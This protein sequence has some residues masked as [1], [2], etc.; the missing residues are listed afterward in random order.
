MDP[1][2]LAQKLIEVEASGP[3]HSVQAMVNTAF[4]SHWN[5]LVDRYVK[6]EK[7]RRIME[8]HKKSLTTAE[9]E[10]RGSLGM[11]TTA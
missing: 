4:D 2:R 10:F 5:A 9:R 3:D 7:A 1:Y 6:T 11:K 8:E